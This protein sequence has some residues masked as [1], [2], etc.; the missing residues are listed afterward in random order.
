MVTKSNSRVTIKDVASAAGVS[1]MTVSLALRG[2]RRI[3]SATRQKVHQAASELGY[4]PSQAARAL[5]TNRT[6]MVVCLLPNRVPCFFGAE[7]EGIQSQLD[8]H[9]Y[10]AMLTLT[11][12]SVET[13][14]KILERCGYSFDGIIFT[15]VADMLANEHFIEVMKASG[16]PFVVVGPFADY[17]VDCV[18][19]DEVQAGLNIMDYL[20]RLGHRRIGMVTGIRYRV[21]EKRMEGFRKAFE[22]HGMTFDESLVVSSTVYGPE[23]GYLGMKQLLRRSSQ[24]TAV[25]VDEDLTATGVYRALAEAGLRVPEDVSVFGYDMDDVGMTV[26]PPLTTVNQHPW[27]IGKAAARLMMERL[28]G[29]TNS[30]PEEILIPTELVIRGSVGPP[31]S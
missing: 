17:G 30:G 12:N 4:R 8:S 20:I 14:T 3:A 31:P 24:V 13:T 2:S 5:R 15:P 10:H 7:F 28:S 21:F 22:T 19:N 27:E 23:A 6:H 1:N 9:D 25:C 18:V 29:S 16:K 26:D 11:N